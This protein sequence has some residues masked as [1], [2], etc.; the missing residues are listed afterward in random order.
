M[1]GRQPRSDL[2][3]RAHVEVLLRRFYGRVFADDV[4]A[5][6]FSELRA[7]G[8]ESHLPVMCDFWETVLFRAGLYRGNALHVHRQLHDRHP[9]CAH[10]FARWITLWNSSVDEMYRGPNALRA[11]VQAARI[12]KSMHRRLT[13]SDASELDAV[14]GLPRPPRGARKP[15]E[16]TARMPARTHPRSPC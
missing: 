10:H 5:E 9:L 8:L 7:N 15:G 13:G 3:N 14:G 16:R 12:A 4:L 11:K 2:A 6:P 1:T